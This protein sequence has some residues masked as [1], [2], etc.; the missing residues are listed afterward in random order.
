MRTFFLFVTVLGLVVSLGSVI[1]AQDTAADEEAIRQLD[2]RYGEAWNNRDAKALAQLF[3]EDADVIDVDGEAVT[4]HMAIEENFVEEFSSRPEGA[5]LDFEAVSIRFI[6]PTIAVADGAWA[7]TGLPEAEGG[8][9]AQGLYTTVYIMK[10]GQ[11]LIAADRSRV[12]MVPPS[13]E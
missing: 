1:V 5:R 3:T 4:G 11:W 10:D 6:R 8:P 12:P 9:P 2:E 13:T 7:I